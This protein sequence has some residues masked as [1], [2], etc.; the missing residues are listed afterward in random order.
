MISLFVL[1]KKNHLK[2]LTALVFCTLSSCGDS[3]PSASVP[4]A[5]PAQPS[6]EEAAA[7]ARKKAEI[8][9]AERKQAAE[10]AKEEARLKLEAEKKAKEDE[11]MAVEA[12]KKAEEEAVVATAKAEFEKKME[13]AFADLALEPKFTFANALEKAGSTAELRGPKLAKLREMLEAK[14]WVEL[15]KDAGQTSTDH[16]TGVLRLEQIPLART[17]VDKME[18]PLVVKLPVVSEDSGNSKSEYYLISEQNLQVVSVSERHPDGDAY[19]VKWSPELG[20]CLVFK[21]QLPRDPR[22]L[23]G[24]VWSQALKDEKKRLEEKIDLGEEDKESMRK[25]MQQKRLELVAEIRAWAGITEDG[26]QHPLQPAVQAFQ[27]KDFP[28]LEKVLRAEAENSPDNHL[29]KAANLTALIIKNLAEVDSIPERVRVANEEYARLNL[30][31]A[32]PQPDEQ[33]DALSKKALEVRD[34]VSGLPMQRGILE[35]EAREA[36]KELGT[37]LHSKI[38]F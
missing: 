32:Q 38:A 9:E 31:A 28:T 20:D 14:A 4:E 26:G 17:R 33:R 22:L 36:Y 1:L 19:V 30:A 23:F 37:I 21:G 34:S 8:A 25:K 13:T 35:H 18:F 24:N 27:D 6:Q 11:R 15:M 3:Q 12:K 5:V 29:L 10:T 7:L 2:L 16:K